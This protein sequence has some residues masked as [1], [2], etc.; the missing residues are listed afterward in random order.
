MNK[1][2]SKRCINYRFGHLIRHSSSLAEQEKAEFANRRNKILQD[3]D[4]YYKTLTDLRNS[5]VERLRIPQFREKF[6]NYQWPENHR[7]DELYSIEGKIHSIRKSGKG[8]VF[9]DVV[10]DFTKVQ[11]VLM[12]KLIGITKD[13]MGQ[14]HDFFKQ[15]DYIIANG[16]PGITNVGELSIKCTEVLRL[17]SPSLYPIPTK[18]THSDKRNHN[19]VV[20]FLANKNAQDSI[21]IRS[22]VINTLRSFLT[23]RGFLEVSTPIIATSSKGANATPFITHSKH[24]KDSNEKPLDLQLRVAP[25]LWLKKM[26]IGGFDKVFEIGPVFRNEG[27]DSTHNC[28]FT[29]CEFYQS[30]TTLEELMEL[31]ELFFQ[32]VSSTLKQF[33]QALQISESLFDEP[34]QKLE[35]I[36]TIEQQT[37]VDLPLKLTPTSLATYFQSIKLEPPTIKSTPHYLDKL[38]S[39][40]IEPLCNKPTFI[41]H[42]PSIMSPLAKSTT[43]TYGDRTY[44]ISRRF[45]LFIKGKEYVN[46]YEEENSPFE[47]ELKFK[48]QQRFKN[49]YNDEESMVPDDAYIK[50]MEWGMPPTGG[51]GIGIDRLC[52]LFSGNERIEEVLTF[53]T[54][55]DVVKQ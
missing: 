49:D 52:M 9:V 47:Q 5:N 48:Q 8:M 20:D 16:Y 54:L 38:S 10:Q 32:N 1:L 43:L 55:T 34:F 33:P 2:I 51:W 19:R 41:Y 7:I 23:D 35:F 53:G 21:I 37:G 45:E 46:A 29:T 15:G 27:I 24:M 26:I 3:P 36:P 28:E 4:Q 44:S 6:A 11:L 39:S 14:H 13:E 31:T 42:Q 40:F 50:A 17:A 30:F 25:E 12:N 18:F 22:K